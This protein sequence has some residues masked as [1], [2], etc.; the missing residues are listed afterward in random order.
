MKVIFTKFLCGLV[1]LV[2]TFNIVAEDWI[3]EEVLK[4]L[5]EVRQE[6]K[7]LRGEI[8]SLKQDV[9]NIS[10]PKAKKRQKIVSSVDLGDMPRLGSKDASVVIVE[11]SEFQCPFCTRHFKQ[12]MPL[13]K[14]NYIDSSK[15][16]YVMRDFP[17][18]FHQNARGAAIAV[19]CAA[20]QKETA[21]WAMHDELLE[22]GGPSLN[23]ENY[24]KIAE[25]LK[26]D[27]VKYAKC[28]EEST[29]AKKVDEDI[30]YG[31]QVGVSGTP[32][33]FI[34]QIEGDKIV[35]AKRLVGAQPFSNFSRVID[36]FLTK[37]EKSLANIIRK[38]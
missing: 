2:S 5:T 11:F 34:G 35:N 25:D 32:A 4:Q 20:E 27:T 36:S 10:L 18:S 33:F 19:R 26:L 8:T 1:F 29:I 38:Q 28:L 16:Q 31:Q 9:N 3:T 14:S 15:V 37:K 21:Y 22:K 23:T 30:A 7:Q 12:T 17:L 24:K 13:I 6:L